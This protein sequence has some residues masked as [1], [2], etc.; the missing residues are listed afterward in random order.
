MMMS[1]IADDCDLFSSINLR[2]AYL[3]IATIESNRRVISGFPVP[4]NDISSPF[5]FH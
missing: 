1:M 3:D 2:Y 5:Q 4:S